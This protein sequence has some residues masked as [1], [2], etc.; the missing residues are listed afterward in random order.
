MFGISFC[1]V[2]ELPQ[3][4]ALNGATAHTMTIS[5]DTTLFQNA[6]GYLVS[7]ISK[8]GSYTNLIPVDPASA[9]APFTITELPAGLEYEVGVDAVVGGQRFEVGALANGASTSRQQFFF[10]LPFFL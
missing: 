10:F 7:V 5:W 1:F 6:E 2:S 3:N 8:D 9:T 4:V